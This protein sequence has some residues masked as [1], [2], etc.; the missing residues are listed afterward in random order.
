MESG[1]IFICVSSNQPF[2]PPHLL[3]S[4]TCC[5]KGET[6]HKLFQRRLWSSVMP[7]C[8]IW[9]LLGGCPSAGYKAQSLGHF[10]FFPVSR[11]RTLTMG[12]EAVSSSNSQMMSWLLCP[13]MGRI[14]PLMEALP[15]WEAAS[16]HGGKQIL[17][18]YSPPATADTWLLST[19][20]KPLSRVCCVPLASSSRVMEGQASGNEPALAQIPVQT[21]GSARQVP[22]LC[23]IQRDET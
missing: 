13:K 17:G 6:S 2:I 14:D 11:V 8:E 5:K 20:S 10:E 15:E 12:V 22:E 21:P 7:P 4:S 1:N 19:P 18:R 23:V 3:L 9:G 16:S